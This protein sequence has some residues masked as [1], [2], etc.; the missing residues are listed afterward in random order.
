VT[1]V[2]EVADPTAGGFLLATNQVGVSRTPSDAPGWRQSN[3]GL[4]NTEINDV[5]VAGDTVYAGAAGAVYVWRGTGTE[6]R[7]RKAWP[8]GQYHRER[9]SQTPG[10]ALLRHQQRRLLPTRRGHHLDTVHGRALAGR[11]SPAVT[12]GWPPSASTSLCSLRAACTAPPTVSRGNFTSSKD[13]PRNFHI[14]ERLVVA[15]DKL[16]VF[17][18]RTFE[19]NQMYRSDSLGGKLD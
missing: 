5:I 12:T 14:F 2:L 18:N 16:Y 17:R 10:P 9:H 4:I 11:P 13:L 15:M 3:Q 1:D 8:A 7:I 19:D 6:W